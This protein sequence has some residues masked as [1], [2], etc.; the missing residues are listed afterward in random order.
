MTGPPTFGT[1]LSPNQ[2]GEHRLLIHRQRDARVVRTRTGPDAV[3]CPRLGHGRRSAKACITIHGRPRPSMPDSAAVGAPASNLLRAA[4]GDFASHR[5]T[6]WWINKSGV[7]SYHWLSLTKS[8]R[9]RLAA[10][11]G[12]GS[13][14][15][16]SW[17]P[18]VSESTQLTAGEIPAD[19]IRWTHVG[20]VSVDHGG[21]LVFP[22]VR[23]VPGI[24]RFTISDGPE[25]VAEYI[26]QAAVSLVTRFGLYRSR[27]KKPSLPLDDLCEGQWS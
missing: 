4:C 3:Q 12:A 8:L 2:S 11:G 21:D 18:I 22:S 16:E 1:N 13:D 23:P 6:L 26:G 19:C 20:Q 24:Y 10:V 25:T 15:S 17:S 27:G 7:R 5:R 14:H 9:W